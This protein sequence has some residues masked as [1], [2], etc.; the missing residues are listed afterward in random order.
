MLPG[1]LLVAALTAAAW[2][3]YGHQT[4]DPPADYLY[5]APDSLVELEHPIGL[6]SVAAVFA[7][8]GW[9][10]LEYWLRE[11]RVAWFVILGLL[12]GLGITTGIGGRAI[13]AGVIGANIGGA[14]FVG[15]L[16]VVYAAT[17]VAVGIVAYRIADSPAGHCPRVFTA[18]PGKMIAV[19]ATVIACGAIPFATVSIF[20][21]SFD[22][23]SAEY[24]GLLVLGVVS[25]AALIAG[26][27][28][29]CLAACSAV[30]LVLFM[31]AD[32]VRK[33]QRRW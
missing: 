7:A 6:I 28:L 21:R 30:W 31:P 22:A 10:A 12:S 25:A 27:V 13:T 16:P 33:R 8:L 32:M 26:L 23:I 24:G 17:A 29:V 18:K 9:L 19:A 14:F 20:D 5:R 15:G 4:V 2:H 1:G 3:L 11:W